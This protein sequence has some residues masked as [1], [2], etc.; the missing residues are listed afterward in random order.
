MLDR[1]R[2]GLEGLIPRAGAPPRVADA[3]GARRL[4]EA[5]DAFLATDRERYARL[6]L[7]GEVVPIG[8]GERTW[9]PPA[10]RAGLVRRGPGGVAVPAA[11]LF[12][13]D[14][15]FVATDLLS[16]D[17]EDQ[18]F[19]LMLE[20][21]HLVRAMDVRP[22]ESV[23]EL[24]VGSGVNA[25]FAS[26]RAA[27]VVGVDVSE[28]A[29]A[30][31]AFN[32]V[33]NPGACPVELRRGSLWDPLA[34]DERFDLVLVNPPFE[35]VPPGTPHFLHSAAGEDGLDVV[36]ALLPQLPDRLRPGGR[37]QI[38]SWSPATEASDGGSGGRSGDVL[39]A[40][41][42]AE[43]FP[44]RRVQVH[45]LDDQPLDVRIDR[46]ADRPGYPEWRARLLAA[47]HAR[48]P[49]VWVQVGPEAGRIEVSSPAEGLR[50]CRDVLAEWR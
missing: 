8:D 31:A 7:R 2:R 36:R 22:G 41:L 4:H 32:T 34:P 40:R 12:P 11:R 15:A 21:V 33:L 35:P 10:E 44:G 19:S 5:L 9:F 30:F 39:L 24:C 16:Y 18:V 38:V 47:G 48:M 3:A 43:R 6:F 29:L 14:G 28:R 17:G 46:F 27:R 1:L 37:A 20:Q 23:L 25:L 26:D 50:E 42:V 49:L 13:W 45:L